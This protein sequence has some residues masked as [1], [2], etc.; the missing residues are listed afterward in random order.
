MLHDRRRHC[1]WAKSTELFQ[2]G[3]D[4][5]DHD[6]ILCIAENPNNDKDS[7]HQLL[8]SDDFFKTSHEP[9]VFNDRTVA[10]MVN[11][12]SVKG[13]IVV[14]AKAVASKELVLYVTK[15]TETWHRAIFGEHRIEEDS[16]T[17]LESTN[18]SLQ[19]Q[20]TTEV[21]MNMGV[22]FSSNS[23]GTYF[24]KLH[25][26]VNRDEYG[27]MDFEKIPNIQGVF[28]INIVDNW[29]EA[30][31]NPLPILKHIKS[32]ITF[33]DGRTFEALKVGGDEL[34][35]H[36]V[37]DLSNTGRVFSS[38]APGILM[39]NGNTGD[40]L[41]LKSTDPDLFVSDDAGRSWKTTPLKG[42]HK[43]EFGDQ[44]G[45]LV[46]I[47]SEL[48]D[49]LSYSID[50]GKTWEELDL[51][52][53]VLAFELTTVP[54]STSMKFLLS[55]EDVERNWYL[56]ALDFNE[57]H[58]RKC[59][60]DDFEKWYA[61]LDPEGKPDCIMG[62]TQHFQ[63]R[64]A[65]AKCTIGVEFKEALPVSEK[66]DCTDEDFECDF[67]F[68]RVHSGKDCELVGK[69]LDPEGQCKTREDKF[70]GSSGWRLIPGND[71]ERRKGAQKDEL[72]EHSCEEVLGNIA[73]GEIQATFHSFTGS[74]FRATY[75]LERDPKLNGDDET[76]LA[77][78]DQIVWKS[79]D[80]GKTW[81]EAVPGDHETIL[82]IYPH[83]FNNDYV[84]FLTNTKT[85]Y[86]SKDRAKHIH[87]FEAPDVPNVDG[88][89]AL[90][91]HQKRPDWLLW[92]G[93]RECSKS[94][95]DYCRVTAH[96]SQKNGAMDSWELLLPYVKRCQF[97][98]RE[99]RKNDESLIF[100][101]H[102]KTESPDGPLQL[103]SSNDTFVTKKQVF[104]DVVDF[105]TMAEFIIVAAKSEDKQYLSAYA[106]ID[107]A[108]FAHA[109]FPKNFPVKHE[110]AYTVLDSETN[111]IFLHVTEYAEK[112]REYGPI[113][114]SNT[115]G[116]SYVIS[117]RDVN[118]DSRGYVDWEKVAGIEGVAIVNVVGN[119]ED[120]KKGVSKKVKTMIT[121]DDGSTWSYLRCP[122]KDL[123]G[124]SSSCDADDLSK[125][126]LH[127]H[128]YTERKD[129]RDTF[130]SPSA[131]G[132]MIGVGNVGEYLGLYNEGNTYMT[133]DGGVTWTQIQ[134]GTFMWE[135]GD[136]GSIIVLVERN[137]PTNKILY[138]IDEGATWHEKVFDD[139]GVTT[140]ERITTVPS[141]N[142]R[143]FLLW[144]TKDRKL[145]TVNLDFTGMTETKCFLP[146]KEH[147]DDPKSDYDL[148]SPAHPNK[149][150]E[151][152]CLF[153]HQSLYYRKKPDSNCYNG[154]LIDRLHTIEKNCTCTRQD[155]EW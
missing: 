152:E 117:I 41:K 116:T 59:E 79:H 107:G 119:V 126:S 69:L 1:N 103:L 111:A 53:K 151:V 57:L 10:G 81:S 128:G 30:E 99:K 22:L 82:A 132:L 130:S 28:L 109:A 90:A 60:K 105:A 7:Q 80:H 101:E 147:Y 110:S 45:I 35:L 136:Q 93:D 129:P 97:M 88:L 2:T 61:R 38:L 54:D 40:F 44:G 37:T 31:D 15:D 21:G 102:W 13:F 150:E 134:K 98:Y 23:N 125:R 77:Q 36:S 52:R 39:G 72:K 95:S 65:D 89:P 124:K 122:E 16:Y 19:V 146:D 29:K 87:R 70:M 63:R 149:K 20:V 144:G 155:F 67:N 27:I 51:G 25:E 84:Y 135:Y 48:T 12:A 33:D 137:N 153:G 6:R 26:H 127:L 9:K 75:Y 85:V 94:N 145:T 50:H 17:I 24:T 76:V 131:V 73:S 68:R 100:C 74:H 139:D 47:K 71:C 115:N 14:A 64:K 42:P 11:M 114:K 46:A 120:V 86:Y 108:E 62:H 113:M 34:H 121:H 49:K 141:D 106:S 4:K 8:V 148:W 112:D 3:N 83:S 143:N 104:D 96:I 78:I 43:Y 56:Y 55:A 91:F 58:E 123:D 18:Y 92:T 154:P 142:S 118:R 66:C 133:K 32:K 5:F 138:S 140:V